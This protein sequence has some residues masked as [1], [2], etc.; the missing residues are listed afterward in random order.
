[1]VTGVVVFLILGLNLSAVSEDVYE[2]WVA[3]YN[4]PVSA[5]DKANAITV[6]ELGN[7]YVT[8]ES[9]GGI[10]YH[11]ATVKYSSEGTTQWAIR[12][13]G[14][15]SQHDL[16]FALGVDCDENVYVTG[17]SGTIKYTSN[18][19]MN[20]IAPYR[21]SALI[22]DNECNLYVTG[23]NLRTCSGHSQ[24]RV[25]LFTYDTFKYLH[26]GN[27]LWT[28]GDIIGWL[29]PGETANAFMAVDTL[30][31]VYITGTRNTVKYS[32]SAD[33]LWEIPWLSGNDLATDF[34]GNLYLCGSYTTKLTPE[35]SI[36][37]TKPYGGIGIAVSGDSN[38]YVVGGAQNFHIVKFNPNGDTLW[39]KYFNG[40]GNGDDTPSALAIDGSGALYVTGSA[41]NGVSGNDYVTLKYS[42]T[43]E[44]VWEL[45]YNGP[46]NGNDN[47]TDIEVDQIGN[48]FVTGQ[49]AG[50][51][52]SYDYLTIKYSP[53]TP[54]SPKAGD[55]NS[56][57]S[58]SLA[59]IVS[60]VNH[61]F[62]KN[63]YLPCDANLYDC[64]V[65]DR[66]CRYDWNGDQKITLGD[67]IRA[68][69]H[70]FNKP[71]GPWSPVPSLGCCPFL[72]NQ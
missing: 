5:A 40:Q 66:F 19:N 59:D 69:N 67:C 21:G 70:I 48:I 22:V 72:Q 29:L 46:G 11:Y 39:V 13:E 24:D 14:P 60:M 42:P 20:V 50:I 1:M 41:Y 56:D 16:A 30:K 47:A 4:G 57:D 23:A 18:G 61:I 15:D 49:S 10:S 26:I 34:S 27:I 63:V 37:W 55:A 44:I 62:G 8:G 38:I 35:G 64:W 54:S 28:K 36:A 9:W 52:T 58:L 33:S 43:G 31:N 68:I 51:G 25:C 17:T 7:V 65:F 6:S 32:P 71:G 2:A 45:L 53:C 3:R 12:Y